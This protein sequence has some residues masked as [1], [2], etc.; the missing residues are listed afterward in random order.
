MR[1]L[2]LTAAVVLAAAVA[3]AAALDRCE[4]AADGPTAAAPVPEHR[5]R[6]DLTAAGMVPAK[7]RVPKDMMVH[8]LVS[9]APDAPEGI[10]GI[11][12]YEEAAGTLGIGPGLA[13]EFVFLSSRPGDDFAF[14]LGGEVVGRLEVTGSHL[15]AGHE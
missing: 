11:T 8:L 7:V 4:P 2:G 10:L 15:E 9:A 13:R 12:G 5:A 1:R 14:V 3:L 6:V